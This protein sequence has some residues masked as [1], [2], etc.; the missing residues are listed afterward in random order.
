MRCTQNIRGSLLCG[1]CLAVVLSWL[2]T[3]KAKEYRPLLLPEFF[4][5]A[6][7]NINKSLEDSA[8]VKSAYAI[9][10]LDVPRG[11]A[12]SGGFFQSGYS[13]AADTLYDN[14]AGNRVEFRNEYH[15]YDFTWGVR[16]RKF[17]TR[18]SEGG[19]PILSMQLN[20]VSLFFQH[21]VWS[22]RF[23]N[24]VFYWGPELGC[25]FTGN[26]I[27]ETRNKQ[28]K[29][30]ISSPYTFGLFFKPAYYFAGFLFVGASLDCVFTEQVS[31]LMFEPTPKKQIKVTYPAISMHALSLFVGCRIGKWRN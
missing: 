17:F 10:I 27:R 5:G 30:G 20:E 23:P 14:D 21:G 25:M 12:L 16:Y 26:P 2:C 22:Q 11:V 28:Y 3:A 8:N 24:F 19:T 18:I 6:P 15:E 4:I 7:W 31:S 29:I 13:Y 1:M 9:E